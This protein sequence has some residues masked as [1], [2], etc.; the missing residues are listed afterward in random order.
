MTIWTQTPS[1]AEANAVTRNTIADVLGI[2]ITEIGA[3]FVKGTMPVD[4]RTHQPFGILHGGASVVL[5]ESLGSFAA[6]LACEKGFVCVG[7]D[8]N[9]NH[10]RSVKSGLVTG[11]AK[12]VHIGRRTQVWEIRIADEA[13]KTVCVSR[14]T[15]AVIEG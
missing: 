7:L 3:D 10:I 13:D 2:E 14:L 6:N 8:I 11:V 9:A 1:L 4:K 12:A 5:A 15:V